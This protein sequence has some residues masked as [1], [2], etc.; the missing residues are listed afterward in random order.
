M[1]V[2]VYVCVCAGTEDFNGAQLKAVA[3][4][5]GMLALRNENTEIQHEDF[6]EAV[7]VV[8]Q[9]KTNKSL[10]MFS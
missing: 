1:C 7:N 8:K 2:C 4:E 10:A 6:M 9:K 3:V 5:A